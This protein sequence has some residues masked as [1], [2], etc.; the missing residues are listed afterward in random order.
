[1]MILRALLF[2][3]ATAGF[4]PSFQAQQPVAVAQ[5]LPQQHPPSHSTSALF[6]APRDNRDLEDQ[7][8]YNARRKAQ[9]GAG[10]VAAGAVLGGMLLGP[11]GAKMGEKNALGRARQGEMERMGISQ[12]M[13][14]SAQEIGFTL[15]QSVEGLE[16]SRMS[17]ET[18]QQFARRLDRDMTE[19]LEKAKREITAGNEDE[20]RK[21]LLEKKRLEDKLKAT[22]QTC[23]EEKKR[24]S[25]MEQNIQ[26]LEERAMEMESLLRRTV[27]AKTLE[28]S[29][30]ML[31]LDTEDPLLRK[32]RDMGID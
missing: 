30:A 10:E 12:D 24:F 22:L 6:M 20:A 21:L 3:P 5:P 27:G 4:V 19:A 18:Q 8:D 23:A 11:F 31:Q 7:I 29:S 17:L 13:L 26:S 14:D 9:G 25:R 1:M 16:A 15:E 2:L 32:F 28:S